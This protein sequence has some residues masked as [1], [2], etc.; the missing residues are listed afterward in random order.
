MILL[1]LPSNWLYYSAELK[2]ISTP[3]P[4]LNNTISSDGA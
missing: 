2:A 4:Y 1:L 3:T